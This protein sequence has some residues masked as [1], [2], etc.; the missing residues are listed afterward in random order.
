MQHNYDYLIV[1]AG[2][3]AEAAAQALHDNDP[4]AT[5]G[6]VGNEAHPPYDRPPLSKGLWADGKENEIFRPLDKT[7]ARLHSGRSID[8]IDAAQH[9][10]GDDH[11]D[12]YHYGK[13]LLAT[14]GTPRT[15]DIASERLV[16]FRTLDNYRALRHMAQPGK[17][18][19]V[20]GG[21]FIGSELAAS[22]AAN[23]VKVS[24]IFPED[25][26]G[27]RVYPIGLADYLG[28]YYTQHGIDMRPGRLV[29]G[30]QDSDDKLSLQL[31]DGS[32]LKVDAAVAGLG[33]TP[34]TALAEHIGA[35]TDNGILVDECMRTSVADVFAAGDVAAF[36]HPD[37]DGHMRVEHENCAITTGYRAG[38][39]MAGKP[40]PYTELPF[41]YSDLFDLGYEAVG[42]LDARLDMVEDWRVP[43]R[44]GVVYYLE[45]GR[46]RG[47]LLW[48]TWGQVEAARALI[49]EPGPFD[50]DSL[51][52]RIVG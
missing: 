37:L 29:N 49:A 20:I 51:R 45:E 50:E 5:I 48:N 7:G 18:V 10:A 40:E 30:G 47:V 43:F 6:M 21:G 8:R 46:V 22:M 12:S 13:L 28:E 2:M 16:H 32:K 15:L 41:F 9:L 11:G 1:G 33:I 38:L 23:D 17:H 31:D 52:H 25:Y 27:E 3:T 14:G 24:M 44:E 26:L 35:K 42:R 4:D 36:P 34:N 19:A 39:A